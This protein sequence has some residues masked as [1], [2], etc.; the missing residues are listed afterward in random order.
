MPTLRPPSPLGLRQF[1]T[2]RAGKRSK[3]EIPP[4]VR[5]LIDLMVFGPPE[6]GEPMN[7]KSAAAHMKI[8]IDTAGQYLRHPLGRARY[9]ELCRMLRDGEHVQNIRAA[10]DVRD[11]EVNRETA[12]GSRARIEAAKYLDGV[13]DN[14][15]HVV[16][17]NVGVA[18]S[19][20]GYLVD[21]SRYDP[22]EVAKVLAKAGSRSNVLDLQAEK[23]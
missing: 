23:S 9:M 15:S 13:H 17:V 2:R 18:M 19:M 1:P 7:L 12:A 10:I 22:S 4:R 3:G 5:E 8:K 6:G 16:N 14:G 20:P 11:S 21:T